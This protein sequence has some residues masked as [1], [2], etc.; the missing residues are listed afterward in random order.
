[1]FLPW[2]I[3]NKRFINSFSQYKVSLMMMIAPN[4]RA[5]K[6]GEVKLRGGGGEC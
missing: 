6:V 1:M 5:R 3:C 4:S 2:K